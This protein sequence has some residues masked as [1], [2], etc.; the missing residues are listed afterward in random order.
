MLLILR[1]H[2]KKQKNRDGGRCDRSDSESCGVN[3]S[4]IEQE[5]VTGQY[6]IT[7]GDM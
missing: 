5:T 3:C 1:F 4:L 6:T 2:R 7:E